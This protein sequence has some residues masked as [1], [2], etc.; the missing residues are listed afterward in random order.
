[1]SWGLDRL[2]RMHFASVPALVRGRRPASAAMLWPEGAT[3]APHVRAGAEEARAADEEG[4]VRAQPQRHAKGRDV[5]TSAAK[6]RSRPSAG[7]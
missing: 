4:E 1:M 3:L 7:G 6:S 2:S 5:R